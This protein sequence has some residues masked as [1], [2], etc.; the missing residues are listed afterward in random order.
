MSGKGIMAMV[1][2]S[3]RINYL[4][5]VRFE[6]PDYIPMIFHINDACYNAYPQEWLF[7]LMAAHPVLFPDF[8]RPDSPHVPVYQPNAQKSRP[9]TDDFGCVWKTSVDGITG[10]VVHHPLAGWAEWE[11]YVFPDPMRCMGIGAIDWEMEERRLEALEQADK[12]VLCGLRHGHT[13]LQLCDIC[14]YQQLLVDMVEEEERLPALIAGVEAFNAGLI[15]RY[16]NMHV[17]IDA[18]LFAE[19]LGMQ[20]GPMISPALFRRYIK[21]SYRRLIEP[22]RARGISVHMHSDGDVRALV[23]DLMDVGVDILNLQDLV[24]GI[25]WI[26]RTLKGKV[27]VDLDIDRQIITPHETPQR[28][29]KLIREEVETLGSKQ[30]GLTMVYG[31]YPGIPLQNIEALMNAM[32]RYAGYYR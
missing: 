23:D 22:V 24:N 31:L 5:A 8:V 16:L 12:P 20:V 9:F 18:F 25:D 19:D 29:D 7:D 1:S 3:S 26:A 17:D 4:K 13:F 30:G 10:T 28:I 6:T 2:Q 32:E 15:R 27:C 14:G 21:P 11:D